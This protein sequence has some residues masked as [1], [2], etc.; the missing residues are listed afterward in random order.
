MN[1]RTDVRSDAPQ[2]PGGSPGADPQVAGKAVVALGPDRLWLADPTSLYVHIPFCA[3]RCHYCDFTTYVAPAAAFDSYVADLTAELA[4]LGA[5]VRR[6]LRTVFFGGGTPTAL[7]AAQWET[8]LTALHAHF[9]VASDAEVTVEANPGSVDD[10]KL[11][12]LRAGGVNRISFGA[13][14]FDDRLL[15]T[16][17]RSHDAAT[18]VDSVKR[19]QAAG[20]ARIN[21]DLMFGLPEQSMDDVNHSLQQLLSL[22]VEHVSAYWL[23]VEA[24][25]PFGKWQAAGLLPLPGEDLEADM[26]ERVREV[27]QAAGYV[28][29]EVSNFARPGGEAQHNLVYWRNQPYFAAGVGAHG[30]V[31][32]HRYENVKSLAAYHGRVAAGHRPTADGHAISAEEACEDTMMLGLRLRE[33]VA[34]EV[35]RARHGVDMTARFGHV[36]DPLVA[37]GW[38]AWRGTTLYLPDRMWPLGNTVFERFVGVEAV[39]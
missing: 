34:A 28:H 3:S 2:A 39:D 23:K 25:T 6:H 7:N 27:L 9:D 13:Q 17:G 5:G 19:A 35:F 29:Y 14:T 30:N 4:L 1:G 22:D 16:I 18:V 36:I 26:Y 31:H 15:M 38:L 33:G 11:R 20:L 32:G 24:G 21:V 8:V 37:Q 10:A 12:A